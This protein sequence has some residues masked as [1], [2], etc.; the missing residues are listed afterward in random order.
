MTAPFYKK[1]LFCLAISSST[2]AAVTFIA[3]NDDNTFNVLDE[4]FNIIGSLTL[5]DAFDS[6][7]TDNTADASESIISSRFNTNETGNQDT[8]T[9]DSTIDF[10]FALVLIQG[11]EFNGA[12]YTNGIADDVGRGG[13]MPNIDVNLSINTNSIF[14]GSLTTGI[15]IPGSTQESGTITDLALNAGEE[16]RLDN[17]EANTEN[18][19]NF[20]TNGDNATQTFTYRLTGNGNNDLSR[21][22]EF[23]TLNIEF[24]IVAVPEP[25]STMLLGLASGLMLIRRKR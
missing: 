22:I 20:V 18:I 5:S 4:S 12:T 7:N 24:D 8:R 10:T 16:I 23:E 6:S 25:S 1:I 19:F 17:P 11:F 9:P 14:N 13:P 3:V 2:Q 21:H 15:A